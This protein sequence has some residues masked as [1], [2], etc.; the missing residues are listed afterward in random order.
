MAG[1]TRDPF[2][3][4]DHQDVP[5]ELAEVPRPPRPAAEEPALA[6]PRPRAPVAYAKPSSGL[7]NLVLWAFAGVGF[8]ALVGGGV[9][10]WKGRPEPAAAPPKPVAWRT[11][12]RGD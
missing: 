8:V 1:S 11:V 4:E 5:L 2:S 10:Y 9:W 3:A 6:L 7:P 12:A